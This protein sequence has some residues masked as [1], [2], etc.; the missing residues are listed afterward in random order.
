MTTNQKRTIAKI[1]TATSH[2]HLQLLL[3]IS[4]YNAPLTIEAIRAYDKRLLELSS[5]VQPT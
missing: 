3:V 5:D 1:K 2:T 4:T